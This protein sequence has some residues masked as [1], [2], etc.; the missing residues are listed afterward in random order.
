M[1]PSSYVFFI[2]FLLV[3]KIYGVDGKVLIERESE[4]ERRRG[5]QSSLCHRFAFLPAGSL[6]SVL[7]CFKT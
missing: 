3:D 6:T 1:S 5:K 7:P 2:P 4:S